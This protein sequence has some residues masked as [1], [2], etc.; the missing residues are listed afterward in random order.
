GRHVLSLDNLHQGLKTSI[1][2]NPTTYSY[3]GQQIV[4][5]SDRTESGLD[6]SLHL[7][8]GEL[9]N[10]E[11]VLVSKIVNRPGER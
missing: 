1:L 4:V 11:A 8:K 5:V 9:L 7:T 3:A 6:G 2:V 10:D